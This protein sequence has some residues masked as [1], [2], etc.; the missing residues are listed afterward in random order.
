[1]INWEGFLYSDGRTAF[2]VSSGTVGGTFPDAAAA[3]AA[4]SGAGAD[5]GQVDNETNI[6]VVLPGHPLAAGL[7]AGLSA[8]WN[9]SPPTVVDEGTGVITF[10]GTRTLI[11]GATV[12][13]T[14]P[15]FSGGGCIVGIDA[16][17]LNF[18]GGSTNKARWVHLP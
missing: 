18:G 12:V 3:Q 8:I 7:P 14:V 5:Y 4:N 11:P 9:P 17:V 16:G 13:A 6:N 10:I 1:M 2:N 15:S